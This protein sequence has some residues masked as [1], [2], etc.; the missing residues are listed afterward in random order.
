MNTEAG[1]ALKTI[2]MNYVVSFSCVAVFALAF[3]G[4]KHENVL[5]I[6]A[7]I[8]IEDTC[9]FKITNNTEHDIYLLPDRNFSLTMV[10]NKVIFAP[11][12]TEPD[13]VFLPNA[14]IPPVMR[15]LKS[16]ESRCIRSEEVLA[17]NDTSCYVRI[18]DIP[19]TKYMIPPNTGYVPDFIEYQKRHSAIVRCKVVNKKEICSDI[20]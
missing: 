16:H 15:A 18:Y 9:I 8:A 5:K 3:W 11:F 10:K 14:F 6:E 20:N 12:Y 2:V 4:K 7:L 17:K 1:L 19:Y 13:V